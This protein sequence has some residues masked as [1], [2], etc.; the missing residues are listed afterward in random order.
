M[1]L[2]L[3][4]LG[5]CSYPPR[6]EY[7]P[8]TVTADPNIERL[9]VQL[10]QGINEKDPFVVCA[11]Y[12]DPAPRCGAVWRERLRKW[13]VPVELSLDKITGGCAGD[14]RVSFLE[15]TRLG[16]RLRTLTVI[17]LPKVPT[18]TRS[19]TSRSG[20]VS[21]LSSFRATGTAPTSTTGRRAH[22]ISMKP[23]LAAKATTAETRMDSRPCL[24]LAPSPRL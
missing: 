1:T 14:A 22:Q 17:T 16:Q 15:K 9:L 24:A 23:G 10:E 18:I 8:E 3:L 20:T 7:E 12:A 2:A 6:T 21:P 4:A 11:L 5:A 13:T 19:S